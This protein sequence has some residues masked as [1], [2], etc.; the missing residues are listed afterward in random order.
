MMVRTQDLAVYKGKQIPWELNKNQRVPSYT[1]GALISK[2]PL[3]AFVPY[4][5]AV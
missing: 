2:L 5:A 1:R 4:A 3:F